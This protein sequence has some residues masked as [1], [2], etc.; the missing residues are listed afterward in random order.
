MKDPIDAGGIFPPM[1]VQMIGVGEETGRLGDLLEKSSTY[2]DREIE[3][4]IKSLI[5][6]I[7]P[8]M[9]VIVAAIVALIAMSIYFPLFDIVSAL[10]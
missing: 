8:T 10:N 1:V 9:T 4:T 7:E 2:L 5:A 6:K 3:A